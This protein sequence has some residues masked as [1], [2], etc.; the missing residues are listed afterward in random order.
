MKFQWA[1]FLAASWLTCLAPIQVSFGQP[2]QVISPGGFE[3]DAAAGI[4]LDPGAAGIPQDLF[5]PEGAADLQRL[6]DQLNPHTTAAGD[7]IA[8]TPTWAEEQFDAQEQFLRIFTDD[9]AAC[10][11]PPIVAP[12]PVPRPKPGT[13]ALPDLGGIEIRA[14]FLQQLTAAAA[15][16]EALDVTRWQIDLARRVTP[17]DICNSLLVGVIKATGTC[18]TDSTYS[19]ED[20]RVTVIPGAQF[21]PTFLIQLAAKANTLSNSNP[22]SFESHR[23]HVTFG[24]DL[25]LHMQMLIFN[26]EPMYNTGSPLSLVLDREQANTHY[27]SVR[28]D[29]KISDLTTRVRFVFDEMLAK[30]ASQ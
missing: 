19:S 2:A 24:L 3:P 11:P 12:F 29:S 13:L 14:Q 25:D 15:S 6:L 28:S 16:N 9:C 21:L 27:I 18:A 23:Y 4:L 20:A 17:L 5:T 30:L 8:T 7:V 1:F 22:N 10:Y 26:Y